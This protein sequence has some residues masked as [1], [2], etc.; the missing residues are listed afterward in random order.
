[1]GPKLPHARVE[2]GAGNEDHRTTRSA[3]GVEQLSAIVGFDKWHDRSSVQ[4]A[5]YSPASQAKGTHSVPRR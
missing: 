3:I 4:I 5:K 1:M 2:P